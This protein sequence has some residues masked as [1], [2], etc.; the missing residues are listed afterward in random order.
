MDGMGVNINSLS[1]KNG[2]SKP[3]IDMLADD[4]GATVWR[5]VFDME[6]W[7]STNDDS[8]PSNFNWTYYNALYSNAKFQNLW[9]TLGYMNQKGINSGIALSFMGRAPS[10]MGTDT[11]ISQANEDEWVETMASLMY[12]ARNTAHVNFGMID[13]MNETDWDGIEGP[14]VGATQ[15]V[16]ML[17]K[18]SVRLDALGLS[19]IRFLGPCTASVS[20]G[21]GTYIPAMLADSVVKAKM[22]HFGLHTYSGDAGGAASVVQGTGVNFWMT[23]TADPAQV[24]SLVGQGPSA[25]QVWEGFDSVYNHAILAGR[26][27]TAPNDDVGFV[28]LAYN[29]TTGI[30][31]KRNYFY[32]DQA[33]FKFVTPG[34][35][36]IAAAE[37]TSVILFAFYHQASGRV[38]IIGQNPGSATSFTTTLSNLPAL[39]TMEFYQATSSAFQRLADVTVTGG[40][41]F[42]FSAP[43]GF[44]TLTGV[45]GTASA[46]DVNKDAITNV[47]DVQQCVNQTL[48]L[49]SCTADIN[50]DGI[51]NVIDVQRVV[52][53]A[54]GG[55]C[56]TP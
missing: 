51:C 4:M 55:V 34:S 35:V 16:R 48:G 41:S 28:P 10:W 1:W 30:Y 31:T 17:H 12:Y 33:L 21:V 11:T 46:C 9:G 53:A 52:N 29:S 50:K 47:V 3:A 5:V 42:T 13:P 39:T 25:V 22:A 7:E 45:A 26:G 37:S 49:T 40:T 43:S 44:F 36:R 24:I 19:D 54:L 15:Y 32:Q 18:L 56:V 8:D 2:E 14:Q 27:T 23:E 6:D 38:T 20:T